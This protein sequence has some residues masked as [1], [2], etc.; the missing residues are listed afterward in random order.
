MGMKAIIPDNPKPDKTGSHAASPAHNYGFENG[1]A[2]PVVG[3]QYPE[4]DEPEVPLTVRDRWSEAPL[5]RKCQRRFASVAIEADVTLPLLEKRL[6]V[7]QE[8]MAEALG[9]GDLDAVRRLAHKADNTQHRH[10]AEQQRFGE[11][12]LRERH[13]D[14]LIQDDADRGKVM[15]NYSAP[16]DRRCGLSLNQKFEKYSNHNRRL[17]K[18]RDR[19]WRAEHEGLHPPALSRNAVNIFLTTD[20]HKMNT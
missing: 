3:F 14:M 16:K 1:A 19:L 9:R 20:W 18:A 17:S 4:E 13:G 8:A 7:L 6:D 12:G 11:P 15:R 10:E 2:V 5:Y